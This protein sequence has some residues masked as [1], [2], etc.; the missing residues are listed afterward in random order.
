MTDA[1]ISILE[2]PFSLNRDHLEQ[3]VN[4]QLGTELHNAYDEAN[5]MTVRA[6][7]LDPVRFIIETEYIAYRVA[8]DV[9]V[10]K[11]LGFTTAK[12]SGKIMIDLRTDYRITSDW[13][14]TT[15][16]VIERSEWLERP[17]V[18]VGGLKIGVKWIGNLVLERTQ[19]KLN[20]T[21]DE[22]IQNAFSLHEQINEAWVKLHMPQAADEA[23]N[24]WVEINPESLGMTPLVNLGDRVRGT[25]VVHCRPVV[26][27]GEQR[28]KPSFPP[29]PDLKTIE[30]VPDAGFQLY[31]DATVPYEE[32]T[33]LAGEKV[34]GT[35]VEAGG[36]EVT[37]H[38]LDLSGSNG[39]LMVRATLS[40]A[41]DGDVFVETRPRFNYATKQLELQNF[42]IDLKTRNFIHKTLGF[43]FEKPI[44][45][46]MRRTIEEQL[47]GIP[48]QVRL[49]LADVLGGTEVAPGVQ[50]V[51]DLN[52][53][54][55]VDTLLLPEGIFVKLMIVGK[56]EIRVGGS[57]EVV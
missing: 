27:I 28:P 37:I 45:K 41:F 8:L 56:V 36:R 15:Q 39:M 9:F 19:A 2:M 11:N 52:E 12:A 10:E 47:A 24:A 53:V 29:L 18:N 42:D 14:L 54:Q 46:R 57:E 23:I 34:V 51:G 1:Q 44:E 26:Y 7:L 13:Q 25:V 16:T 49:A 17:E 40:G 4:Q 48:E 33:R 6:L 21:I 5:G 3:M 30:T 32:A 31:V 35:T 43:L 22:Q 50:L 20:A 38:G 55:I